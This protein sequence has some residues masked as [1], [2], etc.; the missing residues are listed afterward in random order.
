MGVTL[1]A[2][3]AVV[4]IGYV[5]LV[6]TGAAKWLV[7]AVLMLTCP[8]MADGADVAGNVFHHTL[9]STED[10]VGIGFHGRGLGEYHVTTTDGC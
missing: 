7:G 2:V 1:Y 10:A 8:V 6:I 9:V 3:A 4:V 5:C